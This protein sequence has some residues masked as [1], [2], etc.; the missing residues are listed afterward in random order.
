MRVSIPPICI[1]LLLG[2]LTTAG[3]AT[4]ER[5]VPRCP[6]PTPT[7]LSA[8]IRSAPDAIVLEFRG[9]DAKFGIRI[10]NSLPPEGK[11]A[12]DRF[13]IA[14]RPGLPK[15]R[16]LIGSN[17]CIEDSALVDV[18]LALKIHRAIEKYRAATAI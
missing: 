2:I 3:T 8:L 11:E 4:A 12:G 18:R 10:F 6:S 1:G 7:A 5:I 17:G 13:Y 16:L 9:E 15:S 14:V